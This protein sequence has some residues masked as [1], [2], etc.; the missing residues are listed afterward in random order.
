[1]TVYLVI[2]IVVIF[3]LAWFLKDT[4]KR[5]RARGYLKASAG[6]YDGAAHNAYQ[7]LAQMENPTPVDIFQR[8]SL[9]RFN[10]LENNLTNRPPHIVRSIIHD[11][12]N[13]A[14]NI[15]TMPAVVHDA[16]N[17]FIMQRIAEFA[18]ML[19]DDEQAWN[20]RGLAQVVRHNQSMT[21]VARRDEAVKKSS[22]KA[23]AIKTALKDAS[24]YTDDRQN[25]HDPMVNNDLR[26]ILGKLRSTAPADLD[27]FACVDEAEEML[28]DYPDKKNNAKA[29]LATI[30]IRHHI[31]TFGE[32]EDRVFAYTWARCDHP[33]NAENSS[34]MKEAIIYAL[35]D[36]VENG[37]QVCINGRCARILNSLA[38]LDFDNDISESGVLTYEAYKNQIFQ[39]TRE[40]VDNAILRAKNSDDPKMVKIG[41]AYENGEE[42]EDGE[43]EE[44]FKKE[45]IKDIDNNMEKYEKKLNV[46]EIHKI[47]QEC[48]IYCAV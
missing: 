14:N 11:Y 41:T 23:G 8:G 29:V 16:Q 45:I 34:L 43:V 47:S 18:Q 15:N 9:L 26:S 46:T 13:V 33:R 21:A 12:T 10:L 4:W 42:I 7:L 3:V 22:T 20:D 1:M 17:E 19:A 32:T 2:F 35:H 6:V 38:T 37:T 28:D 25:V 24:K 31:S 39:E 36:C 40:I 30:R 5:R 48:Y 27:P 44:I